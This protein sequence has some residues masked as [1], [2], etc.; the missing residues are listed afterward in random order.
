MVQ[1]R[2]SMLHVSI[3]ISP[4]SFGVSEQLEPILHHKRGTDYTQECLH[5]LVPITLDSES[6]SL[7][8]LPE[9]GKRL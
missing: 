1:I 8:I 3:S 5:C 7:E 4:G 9:G 6:Q 2:L